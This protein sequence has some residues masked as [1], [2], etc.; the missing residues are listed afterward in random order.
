[1]E[2]EFHRFVPFVD[3]IVHGHSMKRFLALLTVTTATLCTSLGYAQNASVSEELTKK[4]VG[5][6]FQDCSDCPVMVII[7]PGKFLMGSPSDEKRYNQPERPQ[8]LVHIDHPFAIGKFDVTNKEWDACVADGACKD[9]GTHLPWARRPDLPVVMIS[10]NA[11]KVYL[12]WLNA[13]VKALGIS[14]DPY[15]LPTEAEWEYAARA[16]TTT[17]RHWGET[18]GQNNANCS[19]CGS[20]WDQK[21]QP[22]PAG[23]FSPNPFGLYDMI[24]NIMQWTEDCWSESYMGAPTNGTARTTGD[25]TKRAVRGSYF[26]SA[27]INTRAANRI[28]DPITADIAGAVGLD[29]QNETL[30]LRVV[31]T[32]P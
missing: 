16:G 24:G 14:S 30:G 29:F 23:S 22:S 9:L 7:P 25:C 17:A 26:G 6:T 31:K 10:F 1:M 4:A 20:Q 28:G 27:P 11:A 32:V 8:H 2:L 21:Y 5:Q 12:V 19:L 3:T 18:I 13:K 15:R